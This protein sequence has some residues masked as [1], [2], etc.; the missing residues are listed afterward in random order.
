MELWRGECESRTAGY[1][2]KIVNMKQPRGFPRLLQW[3]KYLSDRRKWYEGKQT[4][5]HPVLVWTTRAVVFLHGVPEFSPRKRPVCLLAPNGGQRKETGV[6][7]GSTHVLCLA[8]ADSWGQWRPLCVYS[9]RN[10]SCSIGEGLHDIWV[11]N[12][13]VFQR[14]VDRLRQ[15]KGFLLFAIP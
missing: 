10:S 1:E 11:R 14:W 13:F 6:S 12:L 3:K 7:D 2:T 15:K 5:G 9:P 4:V 8:G